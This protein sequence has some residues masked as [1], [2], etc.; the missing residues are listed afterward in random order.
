MKAG[1]SPGRYP[2]FPICSDTAAVLQEHPAVR[3]VAACHISP[4]RDD[5]LAFVVADDS[6]TDDFLGRKE[7]ASNQIRK[8][9]K[10]YDLS[11]LTKTAAASTF[12]FNIVGWNSSYTRQPIPQEDMREWVDSTVER[13]LALTPTEVLEIGCGTGLLLLRVAPGC[14]RYVGVDFAPSVLMRLREQLA[15][16]E[17]LLKKVEVL[18]RA[19]D[20]FEGFAGNSFST[21]ILNSAAQYFPSL[22]YLNRVLEN[23][24]HVVKP[25]GHI[26]VGDKRN[27]ML[28]RAQAASVE[29]FQ[30]APQT[31]V[32]E[33]R[34]RIQ[35]RLCNE[36]ELVPSPS[37]FLSLKQ[38]FPK[39]SR[40][41]ICPRRG[42]RDNEMTR[43]RFDAILEI[44]TESAPIV[45]ISFLDPPVQGWNLQRIRSL[46]S[47]GRL[48]AI[49]CARI[50]NARV[51]RDV[52]LLAEL[53][54]ANSQ[55]PVSELKERLERN[56]AEG[57][58]PE[59]IVRLA[60]ET[61]YQAT[62]SWACC[63]P[64]GSYDAAFIPAGFSKGSAFPAVHWPQPNRAAYAY[65][66][67]APGQREIREKLVDELLGHCR[68]KLANN[69]VPA[70]LHLVD[71]IPPKNNDGV[72]FEALLAETQAFG[73]F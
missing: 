64:D 20:N 67:N 23:A 27:L 39:I 69:L 22:S 14:K 21:V 5:V 51:T 59:E 36:P 40:V 33:L 68:L 10:T 71:S 37:Y 46:L 11:Q 73:S 72:D 8:W 65:Q 38:R 16:R 12:A 32:A 6:Y 31:S 47:I 19:A 50:R 7:A 13:I 49:G 4:D 30:A 66:S 34:E 35:K 45:E 54:S 3:D 48:E 15:P 43:F 28:W 25:G 60:A 61:G 62:M 55:L 44:G 42:D 26:F 24:L 1:V 70:T 58:H 53:A 41:E 56:A 57:I 9:R 2:Q 52:R 63:Y 17:E 29:A 18:E